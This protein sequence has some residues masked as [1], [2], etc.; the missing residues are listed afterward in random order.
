MG[1]V[2]SKVRL[3][4]VGGDIRLIVYNMYKFGVWRGFCTTRKSSSL[5]AVTLSNRMN[6]H[7]TS[8]LC[9]EFYDL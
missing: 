3:E 5:L 1:R 6:L 2:G 7:L 8:R 9:S 4:D